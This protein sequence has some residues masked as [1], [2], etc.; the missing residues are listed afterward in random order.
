MSSLRRGHANLLCMVPILTDDPRR[1]SILAG[2]NSPLE[3]NDVLGSNF[4]ISR[5]FLYGIG[6]ISTAH[7]P[8]P[9]P[10]DFGRFP[11][12]DVGFGALTYG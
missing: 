3:H 1:E 9:Q 7:Y 4:K 11:H 5:W 2:R 8:T 10:L 6:P 12:K